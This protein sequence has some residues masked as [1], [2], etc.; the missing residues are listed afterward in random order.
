MEYETLTDR[1]ELSQLMKDMAR[2]LGACLVGIATI[3]TLAGGPPSADL[4]YVL[5]GAR[6]A[7]CFALPLDQEKIERYLKK[8][9]HDSHN[10]D[11]IRQ[12]T[13]ASGIAL[14]MSTFLCQLGYPSVPVPA[15]FQYR[16]D[17][18]V[19]YA[20]RKPPVSHRYL[21]VRSGLGHFGISGNLIT[22]EHGPD[23]AL[24]SVVTQ[25]E[26]NPTEPLPESE[27]YCDNCRLCQAVC[28]SG[29]M[30]PDESSKI[31]LGGHEF[32]YAK[33]KTYYRCNYVCGG[34]AGLNPAGKWSTW[35]PSRYPIPEKD[36]EFQQAYNNAADAYIRRP[37]N[38]HLYYNSVKPGFKTEYTC[39][40]CQLVCHPDPEVRKHR[41]RMIIDSGVIVQNED[42]T[43]EAVTPGEAK[44]R[45]SRM[46]PDQRSMYE[47]YDPKKTDP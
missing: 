47:P 31:S 2:N 45:L 24:A 27:N 43:R 32:S 4:T 38:D 35:S 46:S 12:T 33:K 40:F 20:D 16:N 23:I 26:L 36:D 8:E 18:Q 6:S 39:S 37:M 44:K 9:D 17:S 13:L 5:P 22:N 25:A 41:Y 15:N 21:A 1:E 14:E 28:S 34:Y 11:K 10:L 19:S 3:E 29:F 30:S 42:G 7:I